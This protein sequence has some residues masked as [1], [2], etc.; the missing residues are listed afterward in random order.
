M[1]IE[2]AAGRSSAS[3]PPWP[4]RGPGSDTAGRWM[5]PCGCAQQ[6]GAPGT[7]SAP[8]GQLSPCAPPQPALGRG[9]RAGRCL[10]PPNGDRPGDTGRERVPSPLL[11]QNLPGAPRKQPHRCAGAHRTAQRPL[12]PPDPAPG[13]PY[14][15]LRAPAA[16]ASARDVRP[17]SCPSPGSH[18]PSPGEEEDLR[19][20]LSPPPQCRGQEREESPA[21]VMRGG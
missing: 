8:Q 13:G 2:G 10:V 14:P 11:S 19:K 1:A 17:I 18:N 9:V 20:S 7:H 4:W 15:R 3:L 12:Q 21:N 6:L 5:L 16:A